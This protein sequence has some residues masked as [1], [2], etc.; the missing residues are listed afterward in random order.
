MFSVSLTWRRF[1][2]ISPTAQTDAEVVVLLSKKPSRAPRWQSVFDSFSWIIWFLTFAFGYIVGLILYSIHKFHP[3]ETHITIGHAILVPFQCLF[4]EPIWIKNASSP[5]MVLLIAWIWVAFVVVFYYIAALQLK[6]L[7][8]GYNE[9]LIDNYEQFLETGKQVVI[10]KG[11]YWGH[12]VEKIP[13]MANMIKYVKSPLNLDK[14][15]FRN[16]QYVTMAIRDETYNQAI[17]SL[18]DAGVNPFHFGKDVLLD[19]PISWVVRKDCFYRHAITLFLLKCQDYGLTKHYHRKMVFKL[20]NVAMKDFGDKFKLEFGET[21][22]E[23]IFISFTYAMAIFDVFR[24]AYVISIVSFLGE[25]VIAYIFTKYKVSKTVETMLVDKRRCRGEAYV[26]DC[27]RT[28]ERMK[29]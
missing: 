22:K 7:I 23:R 25:I 9:T 3:I 18:D 15:V 2:V 17:R 11:Y 29:H 16:R 27:K 1:Q 21:H 19:S 6:V 14:M 24:W 20:R 10:P 26:K 8:P 12:Y 5:K 28:K 4:M 13:G